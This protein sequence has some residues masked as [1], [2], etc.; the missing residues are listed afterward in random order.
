M[1]N[2]IKIG[3]LN[4]FFLLA[5]TTRNN[6]SSRFG[7]FIEVHFNEKVLN[8]HG[9]TKTIPF[10]LFSI[11]LSEVIYLIIYLKN[12]V[13]VFN[14]KMN[15]IIIYSIVYVLVHRKVFEVHYDLH[16]RIIFMFVSIY[17]LTIQ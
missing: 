16:H 2:R 11:V 6:N 7:K 3:D 12:L 9:K 17:I 1:V 4:C 13:Y 10:S 5:K 8:F 15:E 14:Q